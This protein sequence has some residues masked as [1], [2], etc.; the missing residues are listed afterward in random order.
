VG[1]R[2]YRSSGVLRAR[3]ALAP[4]GGT[5]EVELHREGGGVEGVQRRLHRRNRRWQ[6]AWG[7]DQLRE[8][9]ARDERGGRRGRARGGG[10][11]GRSSGR[12][13][14]DAGRERGAGTRRRARQPDDQRGICI[15]AQRH[16]VDQQWQTQPAAED[17]GRAV[18]L[19]QVNL[20]QGGMDQLQ[21]VPAGRFGHAACRFGLPVIRTQDRSVHPV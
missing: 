4:R 9:D 3:A 13:E 11:A 7:I 19:V 6:P 16:G 21:V 20:G 10:R 8:R 12:C 1:E 14:G 18:D 5:Q 17:A 2:R 15:N